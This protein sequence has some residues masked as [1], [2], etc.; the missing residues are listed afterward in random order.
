MKLKHAIVNVEEE[1]VINAYIS[2]G[3]SVKEYITGF[4]P[5]VTHY[6]APVQA[7]ALMVKTEWGKLKETNDD[8]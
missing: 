1:N 6:D 5:K 7:Y 3:Y 8:E 4:V 2:D